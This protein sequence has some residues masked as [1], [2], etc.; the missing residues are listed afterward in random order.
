MANIPNFESEEFD[1]IKELRKVLTSVLKDLNKDANAPIDVDL[2]EHVLLPIAHVQDYFPPDGYEIAD[3]T[4][5]T[6][7]PATVDIKYI[8][9]IRNV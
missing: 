7:N 3:G 8:Q 5:G 2:G 9:K 6:D 4:R 1:D